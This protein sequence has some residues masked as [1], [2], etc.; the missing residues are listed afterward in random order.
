[1]LPEKK[2]SLK[3]TNKKTKHRTHTYTKHGMSKKDKSQL[4]TLS[5]PKA[6]KIWAK[7]NNKVE[8]DYNLNK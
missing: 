6:G 8:F 2:E 5:T 7:S 1:M 3:Q 4:K